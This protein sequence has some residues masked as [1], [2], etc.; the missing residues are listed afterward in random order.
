MTDPIADMLTRIRNASKVR[1]P[2]VFIPFSKIKLEVV[3]IL[4]K[5]G[6]IAG[7]AEI[8]PDET[9]NKFGGI[10]VELKYTK[11]RKPAITSIKRVSKPGQ[12]IYASK[13]EL[14]KVLNNLGIAI[15]STS[16]G[17][18]TNREAKKAGLGGEIICEIY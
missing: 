12:R 15:L 10:K 16:A 5:Q 1:K 2:E 3:K 8:K 17:I 9:D 4:K 18:M 11:D 14:P 7:Y 6:Y 13:D